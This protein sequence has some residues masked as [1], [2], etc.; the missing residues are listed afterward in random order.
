MLGL[1]RVTR[2]RVVLAFLLLM[3]PSDRLGIEATSARAQAGKT[4]SPPSKNTESVAP[5]RLNAPASLQEAASVIDFRNFPSLERDKVLHQ[6]V[7][8]LAYSLAKPDLSKDMQFYRGKFTEAGWKIESEKIDP[9]LAFGTFRCTK[10]GFVVDV[11][12]CQDP[13]DKKMLVALENQGNV[14]AR[15]ISRPSGAK[16]TQ[17]QSN[18]TIFVTDAKPAEVARFVRAELKPLG[19]RET[20][21]PG[22]PADFEPD[23]NSLVINFIQRGTHINV[24]L[25][26]KDGKTEVM[27]QVGMLKVGLPIMPDAKGRIEHSE[28]PSLHLGYATPSPPEAVLEFYRKEMPALGWSIRPGT[29]KIESGTAKVALD[30]PGKEPLRLELLNKGGPTLV[31]IAKRTGDP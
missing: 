24:L 15:A 5:G 20:A 22:I 2:R 18:V 21:F 26:L 1:N 9:K 28:A 16:V 3:L 25:N 7:V 4:S 11:T 8:S 30:G 23:E 31:L 27:Y 14:D 17:L 13:N 19:W 12:I 6:S 10:Q 29:D